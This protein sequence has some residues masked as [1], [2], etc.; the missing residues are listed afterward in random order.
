MVTEENKN[1]ASGDSSKTTTTAAGPVKCPFCQWKPCFM[2][3]DENYESLLV[4]GSEMEGKGKTNQKIRLALYSEM[5]HL[6]G[7]RP[8]L[9]YCI[10]REIRDAYPPRTKHVNVHGKYYSLFNN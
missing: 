6:Y 8:Q 3:R 7:S 1:T 10:I 2:D 5:S 9:P 4:L